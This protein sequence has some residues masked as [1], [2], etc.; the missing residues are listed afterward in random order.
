M[1]ERSQPG[2]VST[3]PPEGG[4]TMERGLVGELRKV[5]EKIERANMCQKNTRRNT[6]KIPCRTLSR[7]V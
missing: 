4:V 1:F 5:Y 3:F 2:G 7:T 6:R